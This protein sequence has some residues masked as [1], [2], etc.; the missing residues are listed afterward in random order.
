ML[1]QVPAWVAAG[2]RLASGD[3]VPPILEVRPSTLLMGIQAEKSFAQ[4][5]IFFRNLW[6]SSPTAIRRN[7]A[8]RYRLRFVD[9]GPVHE[10]L[11]EAPSTRTGRNGMVRETT[12]MLNW[13][14]N[15]A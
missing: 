13:T 1:G 9:G 7:R 6:K 3:S 2:G 14:V 10:H 4:N 11:L 12:L 8:Y 5:E 15:L